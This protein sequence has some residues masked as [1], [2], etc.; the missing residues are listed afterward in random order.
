M[1]QQ[2]FEQ[3]HQETWTMIAQALEKP[4]MGDSAKLLAEH[5]ILL[6]QHL[7]IAQERQ[8]ET[9][10]VERLNKL[11]LGVYREVYRYR[12]NTRFN[13]FAF[14][15]RDF[16]LSIYQLRYFVLVA[17]LAF[18][19]P[20]LLAGS[21]VYLDDKAV[22]SVIDAKQVR[23][24]E[25]MY[26]PSAKKLGRPREAETDVFMFG[27]YIKNN[28]SIAFKS[29]AGGM[30]FGIGSLVVLFYNG[31]F[32]GTVAG[33]LTRLDYLDTFYPFVIGHG[34]FELIAII[35][36]GAAGLRLGYSIINP[37]QHARLDA[38][39]RAGRDVVPMLY[40]IFLMLVIAAFVEAFWSSSTSL[41]NAVKYTVGTITWLLV[42]LY[43]CSG[44]RY[45]SR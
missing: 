41:P 11:V 10:L 38:L 32:I 33:H 1:K 34:S 29:F 12:S 39:R 9:A 7:S 31:I 36:S 21:W 23:E 20:M 14:L 24:V 16:P 18:V 13:F 26:D 35:F 4:T 45:E 22:Y 15:L 37:G 42:L 27:F 30:L 19:L 2:I 43:C 44:R 17:T 5:Y 40:G 25:N 28:I 3:Q 8:Y 6:C